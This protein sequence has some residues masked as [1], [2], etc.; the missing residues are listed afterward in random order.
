M[1]AKRQAHRQQRQLDAL[2][3]ELQESQARM[4]K[5]NESL[6]SAQRDNDEL[7][8]SNAALRERVQE[9]SACES[10]VAHFDALLAAAEA[11]TATEREAVAEQR[12]ATARAEE[13]TARMQAMLHASGGEVDEM[14][15]EIGQVQS[16]LRAAISE[17]TGTG[18]EVAHPRSGGDRAAALLA[19]AGGSAASAASCQGPP[20]VGSNTTSPRMTQQL[21]TLLSMY[22]ML[23]ARQEERAQ[24]EI[25]TERSRAAA[26]QTE[27]D[28]AKRSAS[29]S[30]M[31]L[32]EMSALALRLEAAEMKCSTLEAEMAR[33]RAS[34]VELE[35]LTVRANDEIRRALESVGVVEGENRELHGR[36]MTLSERLA[37]LV[38][39]CH[40]RHVECYA[41]RRDLH[42]TATHL[43]QVLPSA[44][45]SSPLPAAP[46]APTSAAGAP[47]SDA[48]APS[49]DAALPMVG[50]G[51]AHPAA[52]PPQP[53]APTPLG[54]GRPPPVADGAGDSAPSV[55]HHA[56]ELV[57]HYW[58]ARQA[59]RDANRALRQAT[60]AM[61][62]GAKASVAERAHLVRVS[63]ASLRQ[64]RAHIVQSLAEPQ[65][66]A[67]QQQQAAQASESPPHLPTRSHGYSQRS[68]G[69][70]FVTV[71]SP[72]IPWPHSPHAPVVRLSASAPGLPSAAELRVARAAKLEAVHGA[73]KAML[74]GACPVSS[75]AA[76]G[77]VRGRPVVSIHSACVAPTSPPHSLRRC[78]CV[79]GC[80]VRALVPSFSMHACCG[81]T[82]NYLAEEAVA[83]TTKLQLRSSRLR[84]YDSHMRRTA[85]AA[86]KRPGGDPAEP[87]PGGAVI[88]EHASPT[89][90]DSCRRTASGILDTA[91]SSPQAAP[92]E[93]V[94]PPSM[95]PPTATG[96]PVGGIDA[97]SPLRPLSPGGPPGSMR[98]ATGGALS[99]SMHSPVRIL[100]AL[101]AGGSAARRQ[102]TIARHYG[103]S[104]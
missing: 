68:C 85:S 82:A 73:E 3:A 104:E 57:Q 93:G 20:Y 97:S 74:M 16:R 58:A 76:S 63:L 30:E 88:P 52:P 77:C 41:L 4:A 37:V 19:M 21:D 32:S 29:E 81:R 48:T 24:A 51:P 44:A 94:G 45:P 87:Q 98:S 43:A 70:T 8:A 18:S 79:F 103:F 53:I 25:A 59:L 33:L 28:A 26:L 47:S 54:V 91:L 83:S 23:L 31:R 102:Q 5:A 80:G 12:A 2:A 36:N 40:A 89:A 61:E 86:T 56:R 95:A 50:A 84:T 55:S 92:L 62:L 78:A 71:T 66:A 72:A 6:Q 13:E 15:R 9:L 39:Q 22:A 69:G 64:L 17:L 27:L 101:S 46:V 90:G 67:V 11:A 60:D 34:N 7:T 96:A 75:P 1:N 100:P 35:A 49:P 42:A 99:A 10:Q 65:A 38:Q 14:R